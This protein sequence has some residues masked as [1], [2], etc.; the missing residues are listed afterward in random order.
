MWIRGG[1]LLLGLFHLVNGLFMLAAPE[2]WYG[3]VP[4]VSQ[5]GPINHHFIADIALAFLSSGA[6]LILGTSRARFAGFAALAGATWPA[7]HALLHIW[8]SINEGLPATAKE[9]V[10]TGIGVIVVGAL[11]LALAWLRIR[12]QENA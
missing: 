2:Y 12:Q 4:G 5:T 10:S 3:A 7:L 6:G 8:G 11:G 1:L 9:L